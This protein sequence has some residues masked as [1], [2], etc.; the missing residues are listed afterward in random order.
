MKAK[1]SQNHP[2]ANREAVIARLD[3]QPGDD[4]RAVAALMRERSTRHA[5][6]LTWTSI[7]PASTRSCAAPRRHRPRGR[8]ANSRARRRRHPARAPRRGARNA[9]RRTARARRPGARLDRRRRAPTPIACARRSKRSPPAS[10]CTSSSTT[11]A[12]RRAARRNG[13]RRRVRTR[14]PPAPARQPGAR[15][16]R[17]AGH[18]GRALGPHRQRHLDVGEGTH[19][20][21]GRVQHDP[22]RGGE[23]GQDARDRTRRRTASPS[24]TCCPVTRAR[25][26]STRSCTTARRPPARPKTPIAKGMLA[27][28]PAGR[29]AEAAELGAVDRLPLFARPRAT[30]T[31][32]TCRSTAAA[33]S[34]CKLHRACA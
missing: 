20:R 3:A 33:P 24:T 21:P 14:V 1:L 15:A 25:S 29:F 16:G 9:R 27:T 26:G 30:S 11:P 4:A 19:R 22:R 17:A 2:D 23:L 6:R 28:V 18:A 34:P 10:R 32:S 13:A 12:A 31:A 8:D 7:S 5:R